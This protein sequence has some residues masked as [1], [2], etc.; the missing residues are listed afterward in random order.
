MLI[1]LLRNNT[2]QIGTRTIYSSGGCLFITTE[3]SLYSVAKLSGQG[4]MHFQGEIQTVVTLWD[5]FFFRFVQVNSSDKSLKGGLGNLAVITSN[6]MENVSSDTIGA[7][8]G[9]RFFRHTLFIKHFPPEYLLATRMFVPV[10]TGT[11]NYQIH[12]VDAVIQPRCAS[13]SRFV[14]EERAVKKPIAPPGPLIIFNL[15]KYL[16]STLS[17]P[18]TTTKLVD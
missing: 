7:R 6:T 5:F 1:F 2:S 13:K 11:S 8:S 9:P 15:H 16:F 10:S 3:D 4:Q 18:T 17:T 12:F 14:E